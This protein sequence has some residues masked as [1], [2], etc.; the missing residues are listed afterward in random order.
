MGA[1]WKRE[2]KR[3]SRRMMLLLACCELP[4][5]LRGLFR[6]SMGLLESFIGFLG[7]CLDR[8]G[9][10]SRCFMA[11]EETILGPGQGAPRI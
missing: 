7:A 8:L 9:P 1:K 4:G 2:R 3:K 10:L 5:G 11:V 6:A